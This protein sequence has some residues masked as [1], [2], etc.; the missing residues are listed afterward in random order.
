MK[1]FLRYYLPAFLWAV[2]IFAFSSIPRLMPPHLGLRYHDKIYH[3]IEF[4]I[5]GLLLIQ[6]LRHRYS[7]TQRPAAIGW[8]VALGVLWGALD[9]FH[10]LFVAGREASLLDA[11]ADSGGVLFAAGLAWLWLLK[12]RSAREKKEKTTA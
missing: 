5:F 7:F 9:E 4:A 1:P 11:L 2:I 3:F 8:A 12:R 6:A 10:Q